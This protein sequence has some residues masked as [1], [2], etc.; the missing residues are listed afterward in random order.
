[1]SEFHYK[2]FQT[3]SVKEVFM[4][5]ATFKIQGMSCQHCVMSVKKAVD[6]IEGVK[7]SEV[8]VGAARVIF[9]EP[10]TSKDTISNAIKDAGY[11]VN[12]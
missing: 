7:S 9:D 12:G 8:T 11:T 6:A 5:E 3:N 10:Q 2:P 1:L 4:A